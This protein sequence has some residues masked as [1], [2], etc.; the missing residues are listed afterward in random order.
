[1]ARIRL[2]SIHCVNRN[3]ISGEDEI[4][5]NLDKKKFAG[6]INIHQGQKVLLNTKDH[7]F[8]DNVDVQLVEVDGQ[9]GGNNDDR[10]GTRHVKDNLEVIGG[11][12]SYEAPG[13][14]YTLEYSVFL[15]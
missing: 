8:T 1:M 10:L 15:D 3:D 6:P 12:V 11:L 9:V 5:I 2:I 13:T 7:E 4:N 14:F